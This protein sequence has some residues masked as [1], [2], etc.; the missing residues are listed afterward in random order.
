MLGLHECD[1]CSTPLPDLHP[2]YAPRPGHRRASL[3]TGEIRV[4]G[5]PGT[6]FAAPRLIGHYVADHAYLPPRPFVD[7]VLA[8]DPYG[9][10]PVRFPG[11]GFPWI[12][13]TAI[14]GHVDDGLCGSRR[15]RRPES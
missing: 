2:G 9:P 8:F 5:T 10:W 1:L 4:P 13:D 7:A 3:G 11:I 14:L 6:A 15:L 12:P